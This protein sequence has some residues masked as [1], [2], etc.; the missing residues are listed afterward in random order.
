MHILS[1]SP[2]LGAYVTGVVIGLICGGIL[3]FVVA[4]WLSNR[5][6]A[7]DQAPAVP[8]WL[9]TAAPAP[10]SPLRAVD[11]EPAT[12]RIP[13]VANVVDLPRRTRTW[14]L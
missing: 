14:S 3:A 12:I 9:G 5:A 8:D 10:T 11:P 4:D 1:T 6:A 7:Q 13:A 2:L